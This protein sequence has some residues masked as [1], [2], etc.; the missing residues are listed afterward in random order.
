MSDENFFMKR[1]REEEA[2]ILRTRGKHMCNLSTDYGY[3]DDMPQLERIKCAIRGVNRD[4]LEPVYVYYDRWSII[5]YRQRDL[6]LFE[7]LYPKKEHM[8]EEMLSKKELQD[9]LKNLGISEDA[10]VEN[11][12]KAIKKMVNRDVKGYSLMTQEEKDKR[13]GEKRDLEKKQRKLERQQ[14][15][16]EF[17][18]WI[19]VKFT[20]FCELT[21]KILQFFGIFCAIIFFC[22]AIYY[23]KFKISLGN[24]E[25]L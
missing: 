22:V 1:A 14:R 19:W 25:D 18:E 16:K 3:D 2:A 24:S 4:G 20:K 6:R 7:M 23:L 15:R 21:F 5:T 8:M 9:L 10:Y 12:I 11:A 13:Q 17:N